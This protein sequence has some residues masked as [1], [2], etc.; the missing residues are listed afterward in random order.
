MILTDYLLCDKSIQWDYARQLGIEHAVIR[1]P[2]DSRFDVTDPGHWR[3]IRDRFL[4]AGLRPV[5][6][7][8][9]PNALHGPIKTGGAE[10]DACL[11]KV[12]RMFPIMAELGI[13]TICTNFMAHIGWLR[14]AHDIP[15]RGGA[16]VTGFRL[17]DY[18][19][20]G[21]AISEPELWANLEYFLQAVMPA[22]E[23]YGIRIALHPDDPPLARLGQVSR[24]LV[25]LANIKKALA[26][27]PSDCLGVTFCQATYSAMGEDIVQAATELAKK[28]FFIHFRDIRGTKTDFRETFHDN[29]Q[30]DMARMVALY[31]RLGCDVP[32][33][34]DHVPTMA[35]ETD[36]TP[37]Y[38]TVGRL[39]AIGYLKG[40]ID[41]VK[42]K[43]EG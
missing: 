37:G 25:S 27:Y 31:D 16:L 24:I 43:T 12:I 21:L 33:R 29:G 6:V 40:L 30:T 28:V 39:F 8:P 32:V 7:E 18:Q 20:S 26:L 5:I 3:A 36:Q 34:V 10:R 13:G 15:E 19:P 35:G 22:A 17:A 38:A 9:M 42:S 41:G 11:D 14:T 2:E 4:S 1:L 23:R